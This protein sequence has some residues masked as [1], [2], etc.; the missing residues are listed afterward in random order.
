MSKEK[1]EV[2]VCSLCNKEHETLRERIRC[3]YNCLH[4]IEEEEKNKKKLEEDQK[5]NNAIK[6]LEEQI[7]FLK[8]NEKTLYSEYLSTVET[9]KNAETKLS[10]LKY[11][12]NHTII[13]GFPFD[14]WF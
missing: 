4:R 7:K 8:N 10:E 12:K 6:E 5:K 2:F 14:F 11:G 3:E 13:T 1:K 9:R